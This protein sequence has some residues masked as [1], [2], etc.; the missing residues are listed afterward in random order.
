MHWRIEQPTLWET[1]QRMYVLWY[2]PIQKTAYICDSLNS[3][4]KCFDAIA[5]CTSLSCF[6]TGLYQWSLVGGRDF[7]MWPVAAGEINSAFSVPI[8]RRARISHEMDESW[9]SAC[10]NI[11]RAPSSEFDRATTIVACSQ[12]VW[13]SVACMILSAH[14]TVLHW[15]Q[16]WM[17]WRENASSIDGHSQIATDLSD[18]NQRDATVERRMNAC[19]RA[20]AA[21]NGHVTPPM[22]VSGQTDDEAGRTR[23]ALSSFEAEK[24]RVES[25]EKNDVQSL[26]S[27]ALPVGCCRYRRRSCCRCCCCCDWRQTNPPMIEP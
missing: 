27:E 26:P 23:Q 20:Y 14:E 2:T 8:R 19:R 13:R 18:R 25:R 1:T 10:L 15:I 16:G 4:R 7:C 9:I 6:K 24:G 12:L 22:L 5:R 3:E 21:A 17:K 11:Y